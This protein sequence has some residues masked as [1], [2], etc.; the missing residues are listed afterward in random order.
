M[1]GIN[2]LD[3][4]LGTEMFNK[5]VQV[6][7]TDRGSEFT[8]ADTMEN[9]IDGSRRTRVPMQSEQKGSL[10]N[11]HKELRYILP[12][13]YTFKSLG[14]NSQ[15][16]LNLIISHLNSSP[17]EKLDGKSPIELTMFLYPALMKKL[18]D[19]GITLISIDKITLTPSL[20]K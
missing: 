15:E 20:I 2:K 12:K 18:N 1:I 13:E 9:R 11:N 7:L 14:L 4:I 6:L 19:F 16:K 8:A 3:E 10:E 17:K 5:Y